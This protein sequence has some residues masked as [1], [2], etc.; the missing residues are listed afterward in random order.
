MRAWMV[1]VVALAIALPIA[2]ALRGPLDAMIAHWGWPHFTTRLI[3][4]VGI[5]IVVASV[6][7]LARKLGWV[8]EQTEAGEGTPQ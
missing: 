8:R 5:A 4:I 3:S 1:Y 6:E 2:I 7:A